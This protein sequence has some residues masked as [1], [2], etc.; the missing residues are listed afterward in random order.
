MMQ[1]QDI[2]KNLNDSQIKAVCSP[3]SPQ[4]IIAGPGTGKTRT[5]ISRTLY[6]IYHYQI[7]ASQTVILTFSNKAASELQQRL[8]NETESEKQDVIISTI[9]SFCLKIIKNNYEKV[10]LNKN[11]SI[12]DSKYQQSVIDAFLVERKQTNAEFRSRGVLLAISNFQLKNKP[13]PPFTAQVYEHYN[14]HLKEQNFIDYNQILTLTLKLFKNHQDILSQYQYLYQAILV[15]EFQDTDIVQ[16]EIIKLLAEKHKNLF[17]VADDDQSIYAWR[18]A[19]PQNITTFMT[20]HKIQRPM[21]LNINYRSG[22][23]IIS[24]AQKLV[25]NNDRVEENKAV[26]AAEQNKGDKLTALLFDNEEQELKYIFN[27]ITEWHKNYKIPLSEI[28]VLYPQ[29]HFSNRLTSLFSNKR[30]PH[31]QA[32]GKNLS[33]SVFMQKLMNYLRLIQNPQN[34]LI[35]E[36]LL[37]AELGYQLLIQIRTLQ[38]LRNTTFRQALNYIAKQDEAGYKSQVLISTFIGNIANLI[39]LKNF[40]S[41]EKLLREIIRGSA[42]LNLSHLQ[43]NSKALATYQ[44]EKLNALSQ[45]KVRIW[46]YCKDRKNNFIAISLLE[47]IYG[48]RVYH[49]DYSEKDQ[50]KKDDIVILLEP[51]NVENLPCIYVN[52]FDSV[53][54]KRESVMTALFRWLQTQLMDNP[55]NLFSEYVVF[56][57]ETTDKDPYNCDIVEIAAVKIKEGEII[58]EFQSLIKPEKKIAAEAEAVH[59]ISEDM[60]AQ[61]PKIEEVWEAFS[62]FCSGSIMIAHNG[63]AFDFIVI[64][65]AAKEKQ[66]KRIN[67]IRFDTLIL[68][69]QH[70]PGQSNSID[71]LSARFKLDPGNRHRALDDVKVL[72][73]IFRKLIGH[74]ARVDSKIIAENLTEHIALANL[75][76]HKNRSA[77]DRAINEAGLEK[78]LSPS[79]QI[80]RKFVK[81]FSI[82]ESELLKQINH[83]YNIQPQPAISSNEYLDFFKHLLSLASQFNP[84]EI[85]EAISEY[86][87]FLA[88]INP[89]DTL[90]KAEAISLLTFYAAKGLEFDRVIIMGLEDNNIPSFYS[91]KDDDA[92]G[93]S[94]SQKLQE[95][96]RLLYVGITRAKTEVVLTSVKNRSGRSQK[97]S[98]FLKEIKD[99]IDI[100]YF[101]VI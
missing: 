2:L 96:K 30:I 100:K 70:F 81:A 47:S 44:S 69:R 76:Q 9:H 89:Q 31:Q 92:D 90:G 72:H 83:F 67:N 80:R 77:E 63:Y 49:F 59:H 85:D 53:S 75:Y 58:S 94:Q 32:A 79:S 61:S 16:Y 54:P 51:L 46:V 40:Y 41:F 82:D 55:F 43:K 73:K 28:A 91:Y 86:L 27:K 19:N 4:M 26:E 52:I 78:L 34:E 48:N 18:G 23:K 1:I 33:D 84:Y 68:A 74:S 25:E 56:D 11:F 24:A 42:S 29:H 39:N 13:L 35:L 95:Q 50:L 21:L 22:A 64:D 66:L 12:C 17:V 98:P 60:V 10:G 88:L 71:G 6:H 37:E 93:R 5:I 3:R 8:D 38:K 87:S 15:D 20:D 36:Q 7:P 57:L 101:S 14:N 45:P 97:S 99:D 65:K 62:D